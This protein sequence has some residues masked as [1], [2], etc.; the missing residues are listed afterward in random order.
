[1]DLINLD[2]V[3][4]LTGAKTNEEAALKLK[5]VLE[6]IEDFLGVVLFKT[7]FKDEKISLAYGNCRY[8]R[9]N[10]TP[11]NEVYEIK[12][13][14]PDSGK[15]ESQTAFKYITGGETIDFLNRRVL[16]KPGA[17]RKPSD[18]N[19]ENSPKGSLPYGHTMALRNSIG[20]KVLRSGTGIKAEFGSGAR[21]SPIEY[22]KYLEGRNGNGI[23]P[24][25]WAA[26][27]IFNADTIIE[28]FRKFYGRLK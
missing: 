19:Y 2:R 12:F 23:R 26:S 22:A 20:F 10:H 7:D 14:N 25:L 24:F 15:Y 17:G 4:Q 11:V 3:K 16:K 5:T 6:V 21:K 1:M 8:I 13:F 27:G 18:K 28:K 9:P